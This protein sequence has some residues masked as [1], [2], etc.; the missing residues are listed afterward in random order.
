MHMMI[1]IHL[2][3]MHGP[4]CKSCQDLYQPSRELK[5]CVQQ[6]Y[7]QM[8][9]RCI[10]IIL[11]MEWTPT[12]FGQP[13]GHLQGSKIQRLDTVRSESYCSLIKGVGSDVHERL[14]RPVSIITPL[15]LCMGRG[16]ICLGPLY[17][18]LQALYL[19][20]AP[21]CAMILMASAT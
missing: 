18:L 10:E 12:C 14:Y 15:L 11:S 19:S 6:W 1:F 9:H 2:K 16:S 7:Q 4:K 3:K 5:P 17:A 20:L 21:T 13:C 8:Q